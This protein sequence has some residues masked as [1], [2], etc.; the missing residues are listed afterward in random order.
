M[1]KFM[2]LMRV[3]FCL[4]AT[5]FFLLALTPSVHSDHGGST[6]D[7]IIGQEPEEGM[8][9]Q[10]IKDLAEA[11]HFRIFVDGDFD[12][13]DE[14]LAD[15]FQWIYGYAP[16]R[17]AVGKQPGKDIAMVLAAAFPNDRN[18]EHFQVFSS[19]EGVGDAERFDEG[20][21]DVHVRWTW[22]GTHDGAEL[23]GY[24]ASGKQVVITGIDLFRVDVENRVLTHL[25]QESDISDLINTLEQNAQQE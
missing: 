24:P 20:T 17:F 14:I 7:F 1:K 23:F 19:V 21:V 18:I 12:A 16:N 25:W 4:G 15:D 10:E 3:S 9:N 22:T 5:V 2:S 8:T 6:A 13:A 11:W